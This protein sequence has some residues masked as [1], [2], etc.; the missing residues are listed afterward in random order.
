MKLGALET[1]EEIVS[2]ALGEHLGPFILY[3]AVDFYNP[4]LSRRSEL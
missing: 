4:H 3:T 2:P 1:S